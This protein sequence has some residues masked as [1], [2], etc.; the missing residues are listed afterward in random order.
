MAHDAAIVTTPLALLLFPSDLPSDR[1]NLV[2]ADPMDLIQNNPI[3][4][5]A[6]SCDH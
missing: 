3:T 6:L 2:Y 4:I 1:H 5:A